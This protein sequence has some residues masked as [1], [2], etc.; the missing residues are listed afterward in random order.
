M[1]LYMTMAW[2]A[3]FGTTPG[4]TIQG[5][6]HIPSSA[7]ISSR[8]GTSQEWKLSEALRNIRTKDQE[9]F[10]WILPV[11]ITNGQIRGTPPADVRALLSLLEK[12]SRVKVHRL[13]DDN[14][15][16]LASEAAYPNAMLIHS[17]ESIALWAQLAY[18]ATRHLPGVMW[19]ECGEDGAFMGIRDMYNLALRAPPRISAS[20][21]IYSIS[22]PSGLPLS[23][24]LMLLAAAFDRDISVRDGWIR[25]DVR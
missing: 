21:Q 9:H 23:E 16:I 14:I 2:A 1:K 19:A 13:R 11:D 4:C 6:P 15:I 8:M 25:V 20:G 22:L 18:V 17:G 3:L 7:P 24:A 5:E 12:D 10:G